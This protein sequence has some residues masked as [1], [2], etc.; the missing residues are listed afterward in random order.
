[1]AQDSGRRWHSSRLL[2][3]AALCL[4]IAG[5]ALGKAYNLTP[6]SVVANRFG[7]HP[8]STG[9]VAAWGYDHWGQGITVPTPTPVRQWSPQP[10]WSRVYLPMLLKN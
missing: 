1:M 4:L 8:S 3:Y 5:P 6:T 2:L 10:R 7:A 9:I